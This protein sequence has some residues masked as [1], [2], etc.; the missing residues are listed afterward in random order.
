LQRNKSIKE[1][2]RN[3]LSALKYVLKVTWDTSPVVFVGILLC[4]LIN[5]ALPAG[6]AWVGRCL[7]NVIVDATKVNSK[8]FDPILFWL[9][10]GLGLAVLS[11][12]INV[13]SQFLNRYL[14][15]KIRLKIDLDILEHAGKLDISRFEDPRSQ[16][17]TER[18]KQN[19]S[20]HFIGFT[21][22]MLNLVQSN[23]TIVGL[24]S[25]LFVIEPIIVFVTIPLVL[26]HMYFQWTQ[27]K[28]RFNKEY[29]RATKRRWSA[30]FV[31][32]LTNQHFL[33]EIKLLKLTQNL[34]DRYKHL[35]V[36]FL[37]EDRKI[38]KRGFI[39]NFIFSTIFSLSF[40]GLFA[41]V[42]WRVLS[43]NLTIGDVAMFAGVTRQLQTQLGA[44]AQ[45]ISGIIEESLYIDNLKIFMNMKPRLKEAS[46]AKINNCRGDIRIDN[47]SFKYP[48]SKQP[49]LSDIS[50]HIEPGENISL[51]GM[52]GAGKTTL[53]K[54]IV[55]LYDPNK[56]RIMLD[57]VD[58]RKL[59]LDY[60]YDQVSF[61]FQGG[62][63]Y[64][65]TAS[66]NIAYGNLHYINDRDYID[67]IAS[68][69]DA[70]NMINSMPEKYDTMLGRKFGK[71]DLSGGQWQRLAIARAIA[72]Q[73]SSI[74]ILDEPE[75]RLDAKARYK[76][77]S[78][79]K[80]LIQGR[81]SIIISHRFSTINLADRIVVL[82]QGRIVES[83]S[84][85]DLIKR[86]GHY[87]FLYNINKGEISKYKND[88]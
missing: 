55:R 44:L 53:V 1:K 64:E 21:K 12:T 66:E 58:L 84:H 25:V 20:T 32:M 14:N 9:L 88:L 86:G 15:E 69:A 47:L 85:E 11:I 10:I 78:K 62:N 33:P 63:R 75:A 37:N 74:L 38:Y 40:Y 71:Y 3:F 57:G 87:A 43:G 35:A 23:L 56:G 30:Y 61:V 13:V 16:D 60:L 51:V 17:I 49:V 42:A 31:S 6:I 82:E 81:T 2:T 80:E 28:M 36:E 67:K 4:R 70:K 45:Q 77:F 83:G 73:S 34:I 39:G 24:I 65:A 46:N 48:G 76:L 41:L 79:Y 68:M 72:R 19:T 59:S 54:L 50:I 18:A 7:I 26:P 52:N 29:S 5:S 22:K 8:D 27:S